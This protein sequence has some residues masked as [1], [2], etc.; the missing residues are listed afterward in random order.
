MH[1]A[2][3][4]AVHTFLYNTSLLHSCTALHSAPCCFDL[5]QCIARWSGVAHWGRK[6][7]AVIGGS[8]NTFTAV[9]HNQSHSQ[10]HLRQQC[11]AQCCI[12]GRWTPRLNNFSTMVKFDTANQSQHPSMVVPWLIALLNWLFFFWC[13]VNWVGSGNPSPWDV[14]KLL[15]SFFGQEWTFWTNFF[16]QYPFLIYEDWICAIVSYQGVHI[17]QRGSHFCRPCQSCILLH[18]SEG[19]PLPTQLT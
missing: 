17:W 16:A 6:Q 19:L 7:W 8:H 12:G 1:T 5:L 15:S 9:K 10:Q 4:S 3:G 11:C 18:P 14:A 2:R 13:Y